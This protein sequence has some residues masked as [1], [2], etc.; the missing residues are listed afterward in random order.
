VERPSLEREKGFETERSSEPAQT[1]AENSGSADS[2]SSPNSREP[3]PKSASPRDAVAS[4]ATAEQSIDPVE[5][6]LASALSAAA[7]AGRFDVVSRLADEL[8]ARRVAR[9]A[10]ATALGSRSRDK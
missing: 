2:S 7:A 4:V 5:A 3:E 9:T 8:A 10:E 1:D 6:A